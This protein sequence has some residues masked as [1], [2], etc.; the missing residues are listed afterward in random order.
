MQ[1]FFYSSLRTFPESYVSLRVSII[2]HFYRI[3]LVFLFSL[4]HLDLIILYTGRNSTFVCRTWW[5]A[6][7]LLCCYIFMYC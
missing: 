5:Y 4:E 7:A 2:S 3:L 1:V 6:D